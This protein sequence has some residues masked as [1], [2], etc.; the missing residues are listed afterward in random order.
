MRLN[1][2]KCNFGAFDI[3]LQRHLNDAI[4][5]WFDPSTMVEVQCFPIPT[6][7]TNMKAFLGFTSYDKKF[8][9]S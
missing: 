4:R 7:L 5:I 3:V 2:S 9:K 8:I 1:P 6:T